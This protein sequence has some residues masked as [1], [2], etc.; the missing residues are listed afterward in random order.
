MADRFLDFAISG[1]LVA[2]SLKL[3]N[4]AWTN[5]LSFDHLARAATMV[6]CLNIVGVVGSTAAAVRA[7][8]HSVIL[9][10]EVGASVQF[11]KSYSDLEANGWTSLF[12]PNDSQMKEK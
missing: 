2:L 5:L 12:Y 3:L 9:K 6:A 1:A 11:L 7:D 8:D 10:F 4:H